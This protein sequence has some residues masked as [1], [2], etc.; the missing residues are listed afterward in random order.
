VLKTF[1]ALQAAAEFR[2]QHLPFLKTLEDQDLIREIGLAQAMGQPL[3]LKQLFMNGIASPATVQRR[4]V[5][6]RRL[7][8]VEQTKSAEDGRVI[9]LTLTPSALRVYKRWGKLLRK[10]WKW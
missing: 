6:L 7:G 8:V 10:A 9:T 4:L 5:R 1:R 3:S 2:R